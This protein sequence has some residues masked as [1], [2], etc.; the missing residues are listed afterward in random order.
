MIKSIDNPYGISLEIIDLIQKG[1]SFTLV[2]DKSKFQKH[3]Y[4]Y[5]KLR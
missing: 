1:K 3:T 2:L 5:P 4:L